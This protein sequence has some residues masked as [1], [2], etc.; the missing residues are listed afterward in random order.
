MLNYNVQKS[1]RKIN[2]ENFLKFHKARIG[3][4]C[5]EVPLVPFH[6]LFVCDPFDQII[7]IPRA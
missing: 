4:M 7:Q 2:T 3:H 6:A 1:T 5:M